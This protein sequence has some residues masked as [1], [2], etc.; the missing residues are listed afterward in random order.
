MRLAANLSWLYT[1]QEFSKRIQASAEDGFKHIECMFPYDVPAALLRNKA[2]EA[3]VQWVLI[4]APAGDWSLGER[5]L[6]TAPERRDDFKRSIDKAVQYAQVMGVQKVHVLAG[7]VDLGN[8]DAVERAWACYEDN[9]MWLACAMQTEPIDWLIE[10][11]N[12][13]DVPGYL[14]TQQ[15]DAHALLSRLDKANLG[16]QMDLYHCQKVEGNALQALV[17]Y[18]PT[19]RVKHLQIAGVPGRNE[20]GLEYTDIFHQ[21]HA[22][23]Y[24]GHVGCEYRPKASTREGLGW[25]RSTG[26]S[27]TMKTF[28]TQA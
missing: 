10:P 2:E 20:P 3:G 14:L 26:F 28:D 5:G 23:G 13:I 12:R 24:T 6:A 9:L 19:G 16:V 25:I 17:Q 15:A 21:L 7:V 18:L 1:E 22:M 8:N 4:N 27:G 11:I